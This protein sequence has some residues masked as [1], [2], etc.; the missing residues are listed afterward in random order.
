MKRRSVGILKTLL[1][2][3]ILVIVAL[4]SGEIF[5]RYYLGLGSPPLS[6][7][8]PTIEYLFKPDQDL[9]RFGNRI[10]IN[11]YGM[12]SE[13]FS[14]KKVAGEFRVMVFGDSVVNGGSQTDQNDLATTIL[15]QQLHS[16]IHKNTVVGNISAGSWGPGNWLA[17]AREYGLFDADV[18]ILVVSSHDYADNPNFAP[19]D[20][21]THPTEKPTFALIEAIER[22]L[23]RYLHQ[24]GTTENMKEGS[25]LSLEPS[26]ADVL[27]GLGGLKEFLQFARKQSQSVLV[28]QHWEEGEVKDK[29]PKAGYYRIKEICE[30]VGIP[31][32]SL[33]DRFR[34]SFV[35]GANPYRDNIHPNQLGQKLIAEAIMEELTG[36]K[37]VTTTPV[38]YTR[39]QIQ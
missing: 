5:T 30:K 11:Q 6:V 8:H 19:L 7:T 39:Q 12:R 37:L 34:Q 29:E 25:Q 36:L 16:E 32:V 27:K 33:G 31:T 21:D 38:S 17:Y 24:I 20:R 18:I 14:P 2:R 23:P 9:P 35:R 22:Y 15:K 1:K 10:R 3:S 28:F 4:I 26:D 13:N